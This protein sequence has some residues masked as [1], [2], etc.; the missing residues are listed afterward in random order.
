V[1]PI[2][3]TDMDHRIIKAVLK[4]HDESDPIWAFWVAQEAGCK[5]SDVSGWFRHHGLGFQRQRATWGAWRVRNERRFDPVR[6]AVGHCF[7]AWK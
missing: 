6:L 4:I 3:D 2:A 1:R 7:E 5:P